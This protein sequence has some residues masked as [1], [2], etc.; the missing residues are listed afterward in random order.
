MIKAWFNL[1]YINMGLLKTLLRFSA[2]V[3]LPFLFIHFTWYHEGELPI[4]MDDV[5]YITHDESYYRLLLEGYK[6]P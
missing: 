3:F 1:D 6:A 2:F 5:T 4:Y